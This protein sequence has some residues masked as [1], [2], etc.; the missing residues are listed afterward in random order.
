MAM[1]PIASVPSQ[2]GIATPTF[3][4]IPQNFTHL[5]LRMHLRDTNAA[6]ATNAFLRFNGDGNGN[7]WYH[8]VRA[9][10]TSFTYDTTSGFMGYLI[11]GTIPSNTTALVYGSVIIDIFDYSN[12]SKGKSVKY[13]AGYDA[14]GSGVVT[15]GGGFWNSTAAITSIQCGADSSGNATFTRIDLYGVTAS[16]VTGA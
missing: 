2:S 8:K 16:S 13:T 14:N 4:N 3:S 1:Y 10:G 9:D 12:A 15:F 5:Q 6:V 7:Y 11:L